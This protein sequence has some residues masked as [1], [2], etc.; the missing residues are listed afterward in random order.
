M[1]QTPTNHEPRTRF[2]LTELL[3]R[4]HVAKSINLGRMRDT[5]LTS[6]VLF[7]YIHPPEIDHLRI[8]ILNEGDASKPRKNKTIHPFRS[9]RRSVRPCPP[10]PSWCSAHRGVYF[11]GFRRPRCRAPSDKGKGWVTE[12]SCLCPCMHTQ[13]P[14]RC[15]LSSRHAST[16]TKKTTTLQARSGE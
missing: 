12:R 2:R 15:V 9:C 5:T 11:L 8:L 13:Q 4:T 3:P 6:L 16:S 7:S 14:P 1:D 10:K